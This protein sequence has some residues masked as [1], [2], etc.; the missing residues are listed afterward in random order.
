M[1]Y[2]EG[3]TLRGMD[4]L[5]DLVDLAASRPYLVHLHHCLVMSCSVTY[6]VEMVAR[7]HPAHVFVE[8]H[9][10]AYSALVALAHSALSLRLETDSWHHMVIGL[11]TGIVSLHHMQ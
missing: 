9:L 11:V 8:Q 1:R 5:V 7:E 6:T 10:Q 4:S 2:V 3:R